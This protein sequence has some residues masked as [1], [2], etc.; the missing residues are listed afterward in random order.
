MLMD[1]MGGI[2]VSINLHDNCRVQLTKAG[3]KYMNDLNK[4][5]NR[6]IL[7]SDPSESAPNEM[8][9]RPKLLYHEYTEGEYF[10]SNL[11]FVTEIYQKIRELGLDSPFV[12]DTIEVLTKEN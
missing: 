2:M 4:E 9:V 12:S 5:A 11:L 10:Y 1:R 3:A 7:G 6:F 8:F